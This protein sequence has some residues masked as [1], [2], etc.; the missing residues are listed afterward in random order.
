ME[1]GSLR[2]LR[3]IEDVSDLPL[4]GRPRTEGQGRRPPGPGG[5]LF[6]HT[7]ADEPAVGVL[8]VV[9]HRL[10]QRLRPRARTQRLAVDGAW[11]LLVARLLRDDRRTDR[12]N[13]LARA[14]ILFR[15]PAR[16]PVPS[17]PVQD[18]AG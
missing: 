8:S 10:P 3:A 6:D 13:L 17:L 14:G 15:R 4:V 12:G 5:L 16:V 11:R 7:G 2:P 1:A 9:Q 18:D